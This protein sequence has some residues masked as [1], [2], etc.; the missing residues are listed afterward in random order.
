LKEF[1][2]DPRVVLID[3][4]G[5]GIR[6]A[7]ISGLEIAEGEF[8]TRM[9]AD[10]IMPENKLELFLQKL[11]KNPS[12][13]V[14]GKVSYFSESGI[15]DG[16]QK[17][18]QW[19]NER[20]D[21][22]DFYKEIYRE[23]TLASGN[24]MMRTDILKKCGGFSDLRYPEDYDLLFRWYENGIEIKGIDELTHLWR[25]H[26][27]RTSRTS[28]D[29]SQERFF[30]LKINHFLNHDYQDI[31][32]VLNGTGAKGKLVA[33][34]LIEQKIPFDWVSVEPEKFR[35]GIYQM[36]IKG[37]NEIH[38]RADIQI[39]NASLIDKNEVSKLYDNR[40]IVKSVITL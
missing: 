17:Y 2:S 33:R 38:Y 29:Y 26:P 1:L 37:L 3:N 15:S 24:W 22:Q 20:V 4:K 30:D 31:P 36:P 40:N 14:T 27:A 8:V 39:L 16:Y 6:D 9:D 11:E 21:K 23:C 18:E 12:A 5:A 13:V 32:L 19:L 10:D 28:D 35:A 7:L 25:E 34:I